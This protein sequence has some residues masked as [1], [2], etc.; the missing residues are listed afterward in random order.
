M[1]HNTI[2]ASTDTTRIALDNTDYHDHA[3]QR[4]AIRNYLT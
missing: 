2:M 3:M 1:N 4:A